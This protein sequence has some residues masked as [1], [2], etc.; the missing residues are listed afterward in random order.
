MVY[1]TLQEQ[2]KIE[3]EV[4]WMGYEDL[5]WEP[6]SKVKDWEIYKSYCL[7]LQFGLLAQVQPEVQQ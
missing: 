7:K 4:K 6:Y 2:V 5:S 3:Y 1:G